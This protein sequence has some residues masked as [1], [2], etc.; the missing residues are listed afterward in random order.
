MTIPG[1]WRL[2]CALG[3]VLTLASPASGQDLI[4][5]TPGASEDLRKQLRGASLVAQTLA[6]APVPAG[7]V[8]AA[9]RA[10][11]GRLLG[12]LY[13]RGHYSGVISV[14]VDGREAADV[15]VLDDPERIDRVEIR[16]D[17]GPA[18]RFSETS[19]GPLAGGTELPEEFAPGQ[20]APSGVIRDAVGAAVDAWREAGH[21]RAEP[22]GQDI[23]ANHS[24]QTLA[25]RVTLDPGP[26]LRFGP[27]SVSGNRRVRTE[28]VVAIAG[29]P[30]GDWF[31]TSALRRSAERLR[32]T[33]AF[34]SVAL[35]EAETI[36][37]G[38]LLPIFATV[39]EERPRRIG[40]GAEVSSVEGARLTAY[41]MHRNLL[42]GAE[43]L[44]IDG[45]IAGLGGETGG[46]DYRVA[47][48]FSRPATFTPDT[49]LAFD[50]KAERLLEPD[51]DLTSFEIGAGLDHVFSDS[52]TGKVRVTYRE[53]RVED[54]AG[55]TT[56]R[57]LTLP[58]SA[59]WDRRD[60]KLDPVGG[61][62]LE[63]GAM[64]F[65]G[66]GSTGSGAKLTLDAR[67]Y[68]AFGAEDRF[69]VATRIQ[70]GSV[71]GSALAETPRDFLFYSGGG[72]TVRGQDYQ[73]LGVTALPGG[74]RSGGQHFFGVQ[75]EL[76]S[77]VTERIGVVAFYDAGYVAA[78]DWGDT[79][80]DWH[81]G[82]GLGLRYD[83]GIGPIRVD[84]GVP[85][86]DTSE[87]VQIYIG[88]GQAF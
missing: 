80:G 67:G 1:Y 84:L 49:A 78:D 22:S 55:T 43:R 51:F 47:L 31:S 40:F 50:A 76:R 83:T 29:L 14:R 11:Y 57:A 58:A 34:R 65:V 46:E 33:G 79:F 17:P 53:A 12:A 24:S 21:A 56:F 3:A 61:F 20:P 30:E 19:I 52:L 45:E 37:P 85:L 60:G 62:Y 5:L 27:L 59:I 64:P 41:W 74:V 2:A 15:P 23:A 6:A 8:M 70:V 26:R 87:G 18:F 54:A 39:E 38:G 68:R 42:G 7:D 86:D 32:R 66:F 28:R 77:K 44:R 48:S 9:A 88:I 35:S 75:T 69:V 63:A 36:A 72:G 81:S 73:S 25:A 4:F 82:A 71:L 10:E 16:V 13:A